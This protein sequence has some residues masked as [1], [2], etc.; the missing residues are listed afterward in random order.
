V[1]DVRVLY[2]A[3]VGRS[4]STLL[5]NVLGEYE[6][7]FSTGE[8]HLLFKAL[9]RDTG[10]GCGERVARCPVWSAVLDD[11]RSSGAWDGDPATVRRWQRGEARVVH[12]PRILRRVR[13]DRP[14]GRPALDAYRELLAALY[15]SIA[16][17]TGARAIADSSKT[18]ADAA[19]LPAL[20]GVDPLLVH[21]V[22]D[23]RAVAY[24]H[25]K[26]RPTLDAHRGQEVM[27]RSGP[28][29]LSARW[30]GVNLVTDRVRARYGDARSVL[31]PYERFA[32]S[33]RTTV[34]DLVRLVDV[35]PEPSPFTADDV[36]V[37]GTN[38]NVWGNRNRFVTGPVT[39]RPD[40]DWRREYPP[41][42]RAL[43][44]SLCLPTLGRYGYSARW[45][46]SASEV[47]G[48]GS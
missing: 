13:G 34:E 46:A 22:R 36:V 2:T 32:A 1:S 48:A 35:A 37:L 27:H 5:G 15:A 25:S 19:L 14:S 28:V 3:G 17:V 20:R 31:L 16:R 18:P 23:P 47:V 8:L 44:T 33:P 26:V 45:G 42:R 4:G 29:R 24:S 21:L 41:S 43:V 12:T 10:C 11:L 30:V 38:H 40:D 9:V 39:V 6:G 7:I